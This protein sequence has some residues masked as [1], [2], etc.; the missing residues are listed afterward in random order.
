MGERGTRPGGFGVR[1]FF[2]AVDERRRH[3]ALSWAALAEVVREQSRVLNERL[4]DHPTGPATLGNMGERGGSGQHALVVLRWPDCPPETF[5]VQPR[6]G[7][8]GVALPATDAAHRL[9]WNL[10]SH[11]AALNAARTERAET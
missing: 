7:T 11:Y 2:T 3:E 4:G 1:A 5:V 8:T 6:P 10:P 9:R